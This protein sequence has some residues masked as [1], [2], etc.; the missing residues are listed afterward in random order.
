[1]SKV[2]KTVG[3][4]SIWSRMLLAQRQSDLAFMLKQWFSIQ[5]QHLVLIEF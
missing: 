5:D 1:M 4:Q 3:E 2:I